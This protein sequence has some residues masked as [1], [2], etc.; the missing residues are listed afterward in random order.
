MLTRAGGNIPRSTI[1]APQGLE[2]TFKPKARKLFEN[3][4]YFW[5]Q[6]A[7]SLTIFSWIAWE[8]LCVPVQ[9]G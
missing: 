1:W 3:H 9:A 2:N 7:A 4:H 5:A 8:S 6:C